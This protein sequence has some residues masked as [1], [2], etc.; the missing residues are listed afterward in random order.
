M[1]PLGTN[2][3]KSKDI[4]LLSPPFYLLALI[5]TNA[6]LSGELVVNIHKCYDTFIDMVTKSVGIGA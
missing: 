6:C 4:F 5:V 3:A 1:I 2:W